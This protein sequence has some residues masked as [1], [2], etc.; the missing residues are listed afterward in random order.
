M[1][2]ATIAAPA[3]RASNAEACACSVP[4]RARSASSS[5]GALTARG[6]WSSA[7]SAGLRTSMRSVWRATSEI[8]TRRSRALTGRPSALRASGM[9][10][11]WG[12]PARS[13]AW[14]GEQL[15]ERRP[16]VVEE[17]RLRGERRVNA[18]GLEQR[19]VGAEAFEEKWYERRLVT[20]RRIG[21]ERR[22]TR[23]VRAAVV[24]RQ[25]HADEQHLRAR[26]LR[27]LDH[28]IEV[29]A[30]R[31]EIAAAQSIVAAELDDDDRGLMRREERRQARA[32]A[33]GGVAADA[34]VD[35]V[36]RVAALA[37]PRFEQRRPALSCG[38]A[39]AR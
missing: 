31:R 3:L 35:D 1:L 2:R 33:G 19:V 34:R 36:V 22:E 28:R 23:R 17:A 9:I 7:N 15:L 39:V 14:L 13:S 25:L 24:R 12:G 27:G 26:L 38:Q 6:R 37:K 20:L 5:T 30:R 10:R 8:G 32:A 11:A 29:G 18:V 21:V 4:T 16:H